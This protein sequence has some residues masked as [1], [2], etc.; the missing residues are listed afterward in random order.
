MTLAKDLWKKKEEYESKSAALAKKVKDK[1]GEEFAKGQKMLFELED[2]RDQSYA[3][4]GRK[5][6]ENSEVDIPENVGIWVFFHGE[7][8]T[9]GLVDVAICTTKYFMGWNPFEKAT[10][11]TF[12]IDDK[13]EKTFKFS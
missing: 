11:Y 2:E 6:L 9:K 1:E 10:W 7:G 3:E 5:L 12:N 4:L 8:K 13:L